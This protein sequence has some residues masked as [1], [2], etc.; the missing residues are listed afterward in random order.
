[1]HFP[2]SRKLIAESYYLTILIS[3]C[4]PFLR[5][6]VQIFRYE[7]SASLADWRLGC[8]RLLPMGLN[9]VARTRLEYPPT[10][11]LPLLQIGQDFI[12]IS[13][14][15]EVIMPCL[16]RQAKAKYGFMAFLLVG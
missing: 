10:T 16:R 8:F 12:V 15:L 4:R 5:Q 13:Y 2:E 6:L 14:K 1:M 11:R 3:N 7:P 9:W